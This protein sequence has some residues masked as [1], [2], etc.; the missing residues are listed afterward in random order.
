MGR[1]A[2]RAP[3]PWARTLYRPPKRG[4]LG[5]A[6]TTEKPFDPCAFRLHFEGELTRGHRIPSDILNKASTELQ[7]IV[8]L[9]VMSKKGMPIAQR[10]RIPKEIEQGFTL[11]HGLPEEGGYAEPV[12]IESWHRED[13][14]AQQERE[15]ASQEARDFIRAA[16]D[17]DS[18]RVASIIPFAEYRRR[19]LK[20]LEAMAP[21]PETGILLRE[22]SQKDNIIDICKASSGARIILSKNEKDEIKIRKGYISAKIKKDEYLDVLG[23][24][25]EFP[26]TYVEDSESITDE[27]TGETVQIY[28]EIAYGED[29]KAREVYKIEEVIPVNIDPINVC[30]VRKVSVNL[31][32][33]QSL[34]FEVQF[35]EEESFYSLTGPFGITL[36]AHA[37]PELEDMLY[38]CLA[39]L[40]EE[41]ALE[42]PARLTE[43][44][45]RL[46]NDLRAC[47]EEARDGI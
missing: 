34:I 20:S 22:D 36:G 2:S 9:L 23:S 18:E 27:E 1:A 38:D 24:R 43:Q 7:N 3:L 16:C 37:R 35:D 13:L 33:K 31:R 46:R 41:Y 29:E 6:M 12:R 17:E 40:W 47:L 44:A 19:C 14:F 39:M 10:A 21:R 8:R 5:G 45:Q 11:F 15:E 42:D 4:Y 30:L 28:G 26:K 32:A 25:K